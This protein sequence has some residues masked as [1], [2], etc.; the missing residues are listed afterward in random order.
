[1]SKKI[2]GKAFDLKIFTRLMGFAKIYKLEFLISTVAAIILSLVS[3][4]RPVLLKEIVEIYFESKDKEGILYFSLLMCGFLLAEVFLQ[5]LFIYKVKWLGQHII[6]DIRVKLQ[7]HMLQ[8]KM[9]YFD[10]SSVGKL[11][12]RLVSDTETIAQFFGEGLFMIISDLL[13][14]Q[15][16][17]DSEIRQA[18]KQMK[19]LEKLLLEKGITKDIIRQMENIEYELL[20]MEDANS[21]QNKDNRRT[22]E[23]NRSTFEPHYLDKIPSKKIFLNQ[24]EILERQNLPL[25]SFYKSKVK[26]YF[27][28]N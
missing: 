7:K 26:L 17:G 16:N 24:S 13:K 20:K 5:D 10:T 25:N 12:T 4:A 28:Q 23:T 11:V 22:S 2:T 14:M 8:F 3:V 21:E 9:A 1:M 27:D 6:K 19:D 15:G 18:E